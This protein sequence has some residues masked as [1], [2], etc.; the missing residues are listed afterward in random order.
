VH[1]FD[2]VDISERDMTL[3]NPTSAQKV[4]D[5]GRAAGMKAGTRVIDFGSGFGEPLALWAGEFG[6]YGVGI[7]IRPKACERARA[8]LQQRGLDQQIEIVCMA[9]VDYV[10]E[11]HGY[12][13][14]TCIGASFVWGGFAPAL[15]QLRK[16]IK[17]DG[18]VIIGEPYWLSSNVPAALARR[19]G[20]FGEWELLAMMRAAGF[21]LMY[22]ARASRDEWDRYERENWQGLIAWLRENPDH[23]E[24]DEVAR[25][26]RNSQDEYLRFGREYFGWAMVVLTPAL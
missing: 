25:H 10:F 2:L 22:V 6:I 12:D 1:F 17:P 26:L 15:A 23:P 7:E 19:E 3:V 9:G 14:A 20:F 16:A 11:P 24:R 5:V 4:I 8:S 21:D 18:A 13:V